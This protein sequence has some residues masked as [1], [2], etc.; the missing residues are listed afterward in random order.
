LVLDGLALLAGGG[1]EADVAVFGSGTWVEDEAG[2]RTIAQQEEPLGY[3]TIKA[4]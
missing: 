3:K 4:L 1:C 2:R